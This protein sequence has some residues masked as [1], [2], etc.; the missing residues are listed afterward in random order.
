[1]S[2]MPRTLLPAG[3][4]AAL[5]PT[6]TV[7]SFLRGLIAG[8]LKPV[9]EK[10]WLSS[11]ALAFEAHPIG[12]RRLVPDALYAFAYRNGRGW[13]VLYVGTRIRHKVDTAIGYGAT[14][15]LVRPGAAA[16]E[17]WLIGDL[18]PPLNDGWR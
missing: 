11:R 2:E 17:A 3:G 10:A 8:W 16:D 18:E 12:A 13:R 15:L 7:G 6:E 9:V 14:H 5:G 1:M 4:V